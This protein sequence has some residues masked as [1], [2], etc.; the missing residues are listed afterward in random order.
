[1]D[2]VSRI[3]TTYR[4]TRANPFWFDAVLIGA[5]AVILIFI[6]GFF[7]GGGSVAL[8]LA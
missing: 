8:S 4:W 7:Y 3:E 2:R 5:V 6:T 1:M